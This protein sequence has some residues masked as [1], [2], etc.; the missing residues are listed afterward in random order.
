MKKVF[1]LLI[2]FAFFIEASSCNNLQ[3]EK[4]NEM[5]VSS[6]AETKIQTKDSP[7]D[8]E[9]GVLK[10]YHWQKCEETENEKTISL[11]IPPEVKVIG[12]R[13]FKIA[14]KDYSKN[15]IPIC[16]KIPKDVVLKP[17]AFEAIGPADITFE[18]GRTVIEEKAFYECG[19]Y[20]NEISVTLPKSLYKLE[21]SAFNQEFFEKTFTLKLN[22]GLREVGDYALCATSCDLPDSIQVLGESALWYWRPQN[23]FVLPKELKEI[24][25]TCF[26][27][28]SGCEPKKPIKI[29]AGVKKIGENII[30]YESLPLPVYGVQV[31]KGN[32]YFKSDKNGWLYS[33]DGSILY[34]AYCTEKKMVIPQNVKEIRCQLQLGDHVERWQKV[35]FPN[36]QLKKQYNKKYDLG[37][38]GTGEEL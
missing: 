7:F 5:K 38:L 3:G 8:I 28:N 37:E 25:D 23:G 6:T 31:A 24:G 27:I 36:E 9:N 33:K 21:E 13:A 17:Y 35:I 19:L 34:Y 20:K 22:S 32:R 18:E 2:M 1:F 26:W 11:T 29:P 14:K 16:L 15:F 10:K 12:K 30:Q 4:H